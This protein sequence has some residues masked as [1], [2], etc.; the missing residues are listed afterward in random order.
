MGNQCESVP[1][2]HLAMV[3]QVARAE[4]CD[5][6]EAAIEK[7]D[8][9]RVTRHRRQK[10]QTRTHRSGHAGSRSGWR[11]YEFQVFSNAFND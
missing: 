1:C 8:E 3:G 9:D 7:S 11:T 2:K 5:E 10:F 4:S 6:P